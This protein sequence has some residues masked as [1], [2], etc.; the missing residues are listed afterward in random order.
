[1]GP[2]EREGRKWGESDCARGRGRLHYCAVAALRWWSVRV[3]AFSY[4]TPYRW[5][6]MGQRRQ[7]KL[8]GPSDDQRERNGHAGVAHENTYEVVFRRFAVAYQTE[9]G[10]Q[11]REARSCAG[12]ADLELASLT[13]TRGRA[14]SSRSR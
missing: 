9:K 1:M 6:L 14:R 2:E 10:G 8:L 7:I 5:H 11:I 3:L 4:R 13:R 12:V